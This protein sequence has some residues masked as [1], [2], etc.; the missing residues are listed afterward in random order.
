MLQDS[1]GA[2]DC[3]HLKDYCEA[4]CVQQAAIGAA[5]TDS[6][7]STYPWWGHTH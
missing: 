3:E 1:A 5:A 4:L 7:R 6:D 2:E